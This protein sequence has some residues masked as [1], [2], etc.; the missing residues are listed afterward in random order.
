MSEM[1]PGYY[2]DPEHPG[3]NRRWTGTAWEPLV[4]RR[5]SLIVGLVAAGLWL[6]ALFLPAYPVADGDAIAGLMCAAFGAIYGTWALIAWAGQFLAALIAL[7][8]VLRRRESWLLRSLPLVIC[9]A[10]IAAGASLIGM[11][12]P[13]DEGGDNRG[14]ITG[15]G[16]GFYL[17]AASLL[18]V[19]LT[20][21]LVRR[22]K[23]SSTS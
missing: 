3:K 5:R 15:L 11:D 9:V 16:I 23:E 20:P 12:V 10:A 22:E 18:L 8:G 4:D 14:E 2:L 19:G 1:P 13:L 7:V 21:W 17:W 6:V